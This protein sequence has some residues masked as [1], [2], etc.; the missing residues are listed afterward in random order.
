MIE[1]DIDDGASPD[2]CIKF[3]DPMAT[4]KYVMQFIKNTRLLRILS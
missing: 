2:F 1:P 3:K 4:S